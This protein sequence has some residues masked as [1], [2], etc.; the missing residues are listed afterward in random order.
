MLGPL[1]DLSQP[2]KTPAAA[3]AR[4]V[5]RPFGGPLTAPR[6]TRRVYLAE[7]NDPWLVDDHQNGDARWW[8]DGGSGLCFAAWGCAASFVDHGT[9]PWAAARSWCSS[10]TKQINGRGVDDSSASL[11]M[12]VA[13]FA[14]DGR[15][16]SGITWNNWPTAEL[17]VPRLIAF[18][19]PR[20]GCGFI[21]HEH[22]TDSTE[23]VARPAADNGALRGG[24][25]R[26]AQPGDAASFRHGVQQI[27]N[28]I[29]SGSV[30][31]VVLA[32]AMTARARPDSHFDGRATARQLRKAHPSALCFL[33]ERGRD[34]FVGATPELLARVHSGSVSTHAVAGTRRSDEGNAERLRSS[35]KDAREHA[36]V[37]NAIEND[38]LPL[39]REL[40]VAE[41]C[42]V[43]SAGPVQHLATALRGRL[44]QGVGV[45]D[46]AAALHPTPA[47]GGAPRADALAWLRAHEPLER[48]W[49]GAPVGWIGPNGDG[50]FAVAIRS[51]L[52]SDGEARAFAGAGIVR[53]SLPESEWQE[54]EAKLATVAGCLCTSPSKPPGVQK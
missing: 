23:P 28:E 29:Q 25:A 6:L 9:E 15:H 46:V 10:I 40:S 41:R 38:L 37:L 7:F 44:R 21:V 5:D 27:L 16:S 53:G 36:A 2:A 26:A 32:R 17:V 48:G 12:V 19:D 13:G 14:F 24:W 52:L 31:K 54:T 22:L 1:S 39:C 51:A 8:H 34:A 47:L 49:Y 33:F 3:K 42:E 43:M 50:V 45:L 35:S 20:L 11:P 30:H 4:S 18:R